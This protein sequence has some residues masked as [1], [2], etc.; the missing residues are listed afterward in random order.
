MQEGKRVQ[1]KVQER[2]EGKRKV[3]EGKGR[4][5]SN[6]V[7]GTGGRT[8]K[9]EKQREKEK[10]GRIIRKGRELEGGQGRR[11]GRGG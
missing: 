6:E 5:D 8:G 9:E 11:G 7:K 3:L 2:R 10:H 1:E 4:K